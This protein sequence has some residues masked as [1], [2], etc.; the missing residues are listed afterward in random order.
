[1]EREHKQYSLT[2]KAGLHL[3]TGKITVCSDTSNYGSVSCYAI[4]E[5]ILKEY[6]STHS[7]ALRLTFKT[8]WDF[9]F[10]MQNSL[11]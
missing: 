8:N 5:N 7:T 3:L 11:G 2:L 10:F 1:M 4:C 6:F 9:Q